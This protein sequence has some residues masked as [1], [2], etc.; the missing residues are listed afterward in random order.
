VALVTPQILWHISAAVVRQQN[1]V[2]HPT[3]CVFVSAAA[4]TA[5]TRRQFRSGSPTPPV[6]PLSS[7][8]IPL[9]LRATS[10]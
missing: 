9:G 8:V 3:E 2:T 5:A 6:P 10:W 7:N 1:I 4:S